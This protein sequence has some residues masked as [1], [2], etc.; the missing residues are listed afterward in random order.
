MREILSFLDRKC[1]EF[2]GRDLT[3]RLKGLRYYFNGSEEELNPVDPFWSADL[4]VTPRA[5]FEQDGNV[6]GFIGEI[7][8]AGHPLNNFKAVLSTLCDGERL[9]FSDNLCVVWKA[10]FGD[11][12]PSGGSGVIPEFEAS[13]VYRGRAVVFE[14][15]VY[16]TRCQE[17]LRKIDPRGGNHG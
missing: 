15:E 8:A 16:L 1:T 2:V 12:E 10:A 6:V 11:S 3:V 14:D 4:D 17:E 9:N 7:R 5:F 13:R